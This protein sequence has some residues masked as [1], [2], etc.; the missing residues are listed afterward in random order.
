M[1]RYRP[2]VILALA[3]LLI[4]SLT[5]CGSDS[6]SDSGSSGSSSYVPTMPTVSPYVLMIK[7]ATHSEYGIT[8]G[9]AFDS[10]FADPEWS[11]FKATTGEHVVE[12]EGIFSYDG[13]PATAKI[14]FVLDMDEGTFSAYHLAINGVDQSRLML[15]TLIQKVF[16]SY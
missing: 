5:A 6:S 16:E 8:Y 14:Q 12:F 11:Y 1:K 4:F 13:S 2:I 9:R 7:E 3:A 10:F 15:A